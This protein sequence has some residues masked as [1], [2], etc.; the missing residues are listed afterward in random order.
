MTLRATSVTS[1]A[2]AEFS[3]IR[4]PRDVFSP[5][6]LAT[7]RT[8]GRANPPLRSAILRDCLQKWGDCDCIRASVRS[9]SAG[10]P[11]WVDARLQP[12]RVC[13]TKSAALRGNSRHSFGHHLNVCSAP[14]SCPFTVS[15][16]ISGS[17]WTLPFG[18]SIETSKERQHWRSSWKAP[19]RTFRSRSDVTRHLDLTPLLSSAVIWASHRPITRSEHVQVREGAP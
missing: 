17:G 11:V 2:P 16:R 14:R 7:Q 1:V 12:G 6:W 10:F 3:M 8:S 13:A 15:A 9:L 19:F 18:S 5:F 4:C